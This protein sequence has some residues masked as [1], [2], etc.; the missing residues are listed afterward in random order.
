MSAAHLIDRLASWAAQRA[1]LRAVVLVGSHARGEARPESDV[2][3]VLLCVDP[4][5]AG[6]GP[7]T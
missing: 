5:P 3:L 7:W 2:D 6:C 4:G 1:D